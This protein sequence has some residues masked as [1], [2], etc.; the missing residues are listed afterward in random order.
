VLT[1]AL[2]TC[3]LFYAAGAVNR[4]AHTVDL[5]RLG[6]LLKKM[7]AT[8]GLFLLGGL[9]ISALPPLNGFV[10]EFMIYSGLF[11]GHGLAGE[12]RLARVLVAALLAL[13]GAISALAVTR[14]FG[15]AFLGSPRDP[16]VHCEGEVEGSLLGPMALHGAGILALGLFPH[17]GA[18][19]VAT[20]SALFLGQLGVPPT[21]VLV[22]TAARLAP[23]GRMG[24]LLVGVVAGLALLRWL[25]LPRRSTRHVTWGCGYTAPNPRM[26][27][28]GASFAAPFAGLFEPLLAVLREEQL[29]E[30]PFPHKGRLSSTWVDAVERRMFEVLF[31][32]EEVVSRFGA[33][34]SEDPQISFGLGLV[35]LV[36]MVG[37]LL[38]T[39]E[40]LR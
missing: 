3:L 8:G 38:G 6:G 35:T 26:Q 12:G 23:V 33:R 7:P 9:A 28:T 29:P 20:P 1:H 24:L 16:Q 13:V 37:L 30:G 32:G 17:A 5:E 40:G 18:A 11:H 4:A 15:V 25:L 31:R 21:G 19:L 36:V 39:T 34:I 10:S 27:Y 2:F 22:E 14:A